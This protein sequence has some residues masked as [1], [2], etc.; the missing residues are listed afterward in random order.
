[1]RKRFSKTWRPL[2]RLDVT[3][4]LVGM[5]NGPSPL[6]EKSSHTEAM[7]YAVLSEH[8]GP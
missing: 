4:G 2:R 5:A 8:I 6:W 3:S 7:P 1:M